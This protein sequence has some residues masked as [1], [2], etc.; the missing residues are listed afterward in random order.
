MRRNDNPNKSLRKLLLASDEGV[1]D[2][3]NVIAKPTMEGRQ[4]IFFFFRM[5]IR[6]IQLDCT[7]GSHA[8]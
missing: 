3:E 2:V 5:G 7:S 6:N 8:Y 1:E 4:D